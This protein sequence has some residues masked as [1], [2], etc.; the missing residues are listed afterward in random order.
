MVVKSDARALTGVRAF[1][2]LPLNP[3][4]VRFVVVILR[5]LAASPVMEVN[6]SSGLFCRARASVNSSVPAL[7][8]VLP[9]KVLTPESVKVAAPA[10]VREFAAPEITPA[11]LRL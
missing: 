7:T 5:P 10:L 4:S 1:V 6:A 11:I 2:V 9:L 3:P 8:T